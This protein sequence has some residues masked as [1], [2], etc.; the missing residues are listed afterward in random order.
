VAVADLDHDGR[1]DLIVGNTGLN[2]AWQIW[3]D[4]RPVVHYGDFNGDGTVSVMEAVRVGAVEMPW[5]DRDFLSAGFPDLTTRIATHLDFSKLS[6]EAVLGSN[7]TKS[8]RMACA[9][10]A[11]VVLMNRGDHL[12]LRVLPTE[13]QWSSANAIAVGDANG[14]GNSDVFLAQ[15]DFAVRPEDMRIDSGRGLWL[16]GDGKGGLSPVAGDLSGV[17]VYGEQRGVAIGDVNGDG[18]PDLVVTQNG[19]KTRLFL[20]VAPKPP[21][22]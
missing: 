19:A 22:R 15:N 8:H 5:R 1:P 14:D 9:T 13:A 2:S 17:H 7:A 10:L 3:G 6:V 21:G 11:S 20:N 12:E 4:G 18:R 16:Q